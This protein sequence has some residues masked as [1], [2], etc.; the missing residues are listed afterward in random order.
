MC[1]RGSSVA[2]SLKEQNLP[3]LLG[4]LLGN[5]AVFYLAVTTDSLLEGDWSALAKAWAAAWPGGVGLALAGVANAQFSPMAKARIV[6]LRWHHPLPGAE[7]FTV[8]GPADARVDIAALERAHGPL[9]TDPAAQN[10]LWYRLFKPIQDRPEIQHVHRLYLLARDYT[11][12]SILLLPVL[13]GAGLFAI[14][15]TRTAL[16]FIAAL[17]LQFL[18]ARRAA[19]THGCRLVCNVLALRGAGI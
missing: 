15:S 4:I 5:F 16:L 13:G 1:N 12:L 11:S 2:K 19:R 14:P 3:A 9:P 7:A 8:H 18:L 6:F 10:S 17:V